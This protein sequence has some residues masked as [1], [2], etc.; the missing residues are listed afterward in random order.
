MRG[1]PTA[2]KVILSG[3]LFQT[4]VNDDGLFVFPDVPLGAYVLEVKSPQLTYSKVRVVVTTNEVRATRMSVSDHFS[5]QQQTLP[6]PLTLRPRP[7]PMHYIPPE[8]AKVAGWFANPM[9]LLS[10]FSFLMLLLMPKIMANLDAEALEA[11]RSSYDFG[12]L[13]SLAPPHP[14]GSMA[15]HEPLHTA[16][17]AYQQH[18]PMRNALSAADASAPGSRMAPEKNAANCGLNPAICYRQ[19]LPVLTKKQQ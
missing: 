2:T 14:M 17:L 11:M 8:G 9:I 6:M 19:A 16:Q 3:G 1:V 15:Q 12:C 5:S 7:R 4:L 13:P 18:P 10:S